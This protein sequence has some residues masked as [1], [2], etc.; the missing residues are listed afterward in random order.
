MVFK[1]LSFLFFTNLI[2]FHALNAQNDPLTIVTDAS[3]EVSKEQPD[4]GAYPLSTEAIAATKSGLKGGNA[5]AVEAYFYGASTIIEGT[6]PIWATQKA[7]DD[8]EARQFKKVFMMRN[9][10]I[11]TAAFKINCDDAARV[12]INGQL[13]VGTELNG[14]LRVKMFTTANFK[15]L[16]AYFYNRIFTYD[17]K[18]YLLAGALNTILI[19]VA[20]ES[21]SNG[22]AY[23]C[24]KLDI[25]FVQNTKA[26]EYRVN[27]AV[28]PV[29]KPTIVVKKP[30]E[31]V[32]NPPKK[33]VNETIV[34]TPQPTEK[35]PVST[36]NVFKSSSD[37]DAK[38]MEIGDIFELGN[39]YFKADD[40]QLNST[41]QNTLL[42]LA[43]FL[44]ANTG[45]KIEI[46][47]HT[48]LIPTN[49]Y[50]DKLSSNRA[51]SVVSFLK[52]NG[53]AESRLTFKGYGKS[54]PKLLEKTSEAHQKNQRVEVKILAIN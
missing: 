52:Q 33:E 2:A 47:G 3:W 26:I 50:A 15:Q 16:T 28:K 41:S 8:F 4:F 54:K 24:A 17:I 14:N 34:T 19:E 39:I 46:G 51:Q 49:D 43:T 30:V 29:K 11:N 18:P 35:P 53:I 40:Y 37:L 21:V 20:S 25:T 45:I 38:T 12:Y 23:V 36:P 48:N 6:K 13:I 31:K 9:N 32:I 44:K 7:S 1:I 10:L 5:Q 22:H 27:Q 42:E